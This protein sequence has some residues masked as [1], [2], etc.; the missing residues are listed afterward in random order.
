[1]NKSDI[2]RVQ[3]QKE[4]E[5]QSIESSSDALP[6]TASILISRMPTEDPDQRWTLETARRPYTPPWSMCSST[7]S[8]GYPKAYKRVTSPSKPY[9]SLRETYKNNRN[10]SNNG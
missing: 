5:E 10:P 8:H 2:A 4:V 7:V 9:P 3:S 1:M 6:M